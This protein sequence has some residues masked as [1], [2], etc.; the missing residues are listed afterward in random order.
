MG[1]VN[2][3]TPVDLAQR[4]LSAAVISVIAVECCLAWAIGCIVPLLVTDQPVLPCELLYLPLA[5]SFVCNF[6]HIMVLSLFKSEGAT[7]GTILL[8]GVNLGS[9]QGTLIQ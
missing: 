3:S 5:Y 9:K 4:V 6:S 2:D 8:H 1:P 7:C